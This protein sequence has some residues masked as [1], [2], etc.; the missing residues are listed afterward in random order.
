MCRALIPELD[1]YYYKARIY[2]PKL[3]RFLQ[4]DPVGYEDQVNL[5]AYVG[6]DLSGR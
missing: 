1:V 3:G 5:Y 2:S 4:T 6:N